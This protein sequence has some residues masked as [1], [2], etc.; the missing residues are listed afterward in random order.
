MCAAVPFTSGK[1][2][3]LLLPIPPQSGE[4]CTSNLASQRD[5]NDSLA[6]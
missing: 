4:W 2:R 6:G 5:G 1:V 3:E